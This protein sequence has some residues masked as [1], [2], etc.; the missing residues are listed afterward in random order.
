MKVYPSSTLRLT[1]SVK[2]VQKANRSRF[3]SIVR[4]GCLHLNPWN[5]Y[6]WI[7][8]DLSPQS[9]SVEST[10]GMSSWMTTLGTLGYT[11]SD[12]RMKLFNHLVSYFT[13]T[14]A[15]AVT[16]PALLARMLTTTCSTLLEL[17]G[18]YGGTDIFKLPSLLIF[19]PLC[20]YYCWPLL[21]T[22]LIS[23]ELIALIS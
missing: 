20:Q 11:F 7:Y 15:L 3:L 1:L 21:S 12:L 10:M 14:E 23:H 9:V 2:L 8:L 4:L 22:L 6:T 18:K 16:L 17:M 5:Y 19:L 13:T